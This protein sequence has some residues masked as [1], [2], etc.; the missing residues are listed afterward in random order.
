MLSAEGVAL[1]AKIAM[2]LKLAACSSMHARPPREKKM[3]A[4]MKFPKEL[5]I[6]I[7]PKKVN[8]TIMK[9]WIARRVTE[10]LGGLEEEVLIGLIYNY[11]ELD[12]VRGGSSRGRG[13]EAKAG[14]I[15]RIDVEALSALL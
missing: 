6:K 12:K 7:D 2:Q 3:I 4:K 14:T 15:S 8:W 10:L 5:D 11:L 13:D 9:E 1:L